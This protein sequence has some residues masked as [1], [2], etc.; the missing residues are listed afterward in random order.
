MWLA[1]CL[2]WLTGFLGW[3]LDGLVFFWGGGG[4]GGREL[5]VLLV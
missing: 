2:S 5:V 1:C 4:G 3:L